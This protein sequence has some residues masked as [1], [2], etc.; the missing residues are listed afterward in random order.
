MR[1]LSLPAVSNEIV[2]AAGNLIFVS[3]SPVC[4]IVSARDMSLLASNPPV[5][6]KLDPS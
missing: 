4:F 1:N 3:V 2:S 6:L 5:T